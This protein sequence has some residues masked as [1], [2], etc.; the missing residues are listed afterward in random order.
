MAQD[1][2]IIEIADGREA[3]CQN[4]LA[5]L[6][7]WF[8]I[9]EATANYIGAAGRMPMLAYRSG[10]EIAGFVSLDRTSDAAVDIHVMG[11]LARYHRRGVGRALIE[12][13]GDW[14][15]DQG[16]RL[17]SVKTLGPSHPDPGYA[18]TRKFYEATG[19]LPLEVF[20]ELW[21]PDL[22]CLI[23]VKPLAPA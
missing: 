9:P 14:A 23:M 1:H 12:A 11:V 19:F 2:E 15:R 18:N 16:A 7:D 6:P 13:A 4:I 17:L 5:D 21:G 20:K 22:P 8:G 10:D 3:V